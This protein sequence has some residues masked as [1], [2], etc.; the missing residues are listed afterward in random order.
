MVVRASLDAHWSEDE[1]VLGW[2]YGTLEAADKV[3]G[4]WL[5][6]PGAAA[7]SHRVTTDVTLQ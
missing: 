2:S 7:P 3:T 4:A 5:E 1:L 6:V